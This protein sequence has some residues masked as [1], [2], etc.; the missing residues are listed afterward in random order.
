MERKASLTA[1]DKR[2][3]VAPPIASSHG[4]EVRE[5][6]DKTDVDPHT[7]S[8]PFLFSSESQHMDWYHPGS[9]YVFPPL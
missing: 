1:E 4:R 9:K 3:E 8:F 5:W 2:L 6:G 7:F